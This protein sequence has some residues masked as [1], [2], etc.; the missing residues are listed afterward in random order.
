LSR[1]GIDGSW[2]TFMIQV[3]NPGQGV[4]LLPNTLSNAGNSIWVVIPPGCTEINQNVSD[5][6][7]KRGGMFVSNQSTSWST[8]KLPNYGLFSL[9]TGNEEVQ[10]GL[11]GNAYYGFD[12][13]HLGLSGSG[14]PQ[15]QNQLV[16][17][18]A[19]NDFWLGSLGIS[20]TTFNIT[21]FDSPI[22]SLLGT[23]RS[24]KFVR[25]TTWG[26][27]AGAVYQSP[28]A[29][30]S[31]TFG[32]YDSALFAANASIVVSAGPNFSNDLLIALQSI[33]YDSYGSSPLL[34][35]G[36]LVLI[37]S[38]VAEMWLPIEVCHA[39]EQAF[40]LTWNETHELYI[41]DEK[42]HAN[43]LAQNPTF[44]FTLGG[45]TSAPGGQTI[46]IKFPYAA[47]DLNAT[48]PYAKLTN[49]VPYFPLKRAENSSQ[50]ALGRAFLQ[51]AYIIADY[52]RSQFHV[53]QALFPDLGD[54]PKLTAIEPP[55]PGNNTTPEPRK[56]DKLSEGAIAG[57]AVAAVIVPFSIIAALV[58]VYRRRSDRQRKYKESQ[59]A[60]GMSSDVSELPINPAPLGTQ[61][62]L[63][64]EKPGEVVGTVMAPELDAGFDRVELEAP[65]NS[66]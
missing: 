64:D 31:L 41:L 59:M 9:E 44:T 33:T 8:E 32:G 42:V 29:V 22:P 12:T 21:N 62:L 15:V 66:S 63:V 28:S 65:H 19:T 11:S 54:L 3:G 34:T 37:D 47:F 50:Y 38:M 1:Q 5:C 61:E 18:M 46:Q 58:Y 57:I 16:A 51:E 13:I 39:F 56:D 4:Y 52:D 53:S 26:Y 7:A 23:L 35:N 30:G 49:T 45:S 48:A 14:L 2:S 60:L 6:A 36:T 17:G 24:Q 55:K 25:S 20:P 40:N 10:L 43:L 27:T